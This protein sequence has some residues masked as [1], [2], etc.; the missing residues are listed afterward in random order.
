MK[1]CSSLMEEEWYTPGF[2]RNGWPKVDVELL[3]LGV[4]RV[5]VAGCSFDFMEEL[6]NVNEVTHRNFFHYKFCK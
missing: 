4:L 1:I 6:T 2:A 5:L 3:A